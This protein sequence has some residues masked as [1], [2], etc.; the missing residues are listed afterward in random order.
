MEIQLTNK[1]ITIADKWQDLTLR[2]YLEYAKL[3]NNL[4]SE[5]DLSDMLLVLRMVEI[6]LNLSED[7]LDSYSMTDTNICI[8]KITDLINNLK[9]HKDETVSESIEIDGTTY[10][11]RSLKDLNG[12]STGEYISLETIKTQYANDYTEMATHLLAILVRPATKVFNE[13]TKETVL[14]ID[15][16]DK[17][18]IMNL[19]YRANLFKNVKAGV[20]VPILNFF[21]SGK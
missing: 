6:F 5:G 21:L 15:K 2:Q 1:T 13:E 16:F 10:F 19:E 11:M 14:T 12:I 9:E 7:E 17:K 3:V 8:D 18:D 20:L 4:K